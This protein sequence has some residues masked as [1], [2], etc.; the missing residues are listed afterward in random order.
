[1][2]QAV[3]QR[4]SARFYR[5]A[6]PGVHSKGMKESG[7]VRLSAY[8]VKA[9]WRSEVRPKGHYLFDTSAMKSLASHTTPQ[10]AK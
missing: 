3:S 1:M 2:D 6:H 5:S 8:Y 9:Q 10:A 4:L 7:E